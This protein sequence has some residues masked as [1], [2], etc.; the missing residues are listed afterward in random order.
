VSALLLAAGLA[1][2]ISS[3]LAVRTTR[4][5]RR[6]AR[7]HAAELSRLGA[8]HADV[9]AELT[10][11][12]ADEAAELDRARDDRHAADRAATINKLASSIGH[13]INNPLTSVLSNLDLI[14]SG[15]EGGELDVAELSTMT[16]EALDG[17]HRVRQIVKYLRMFAGSRAAQPG[18]CHELGRFAR[19]AIG[20]VKAEVRQRAQLVIEEADGAPPVLGDEGGLAQIVMCMVEHAVQALPTGRSR[21]HQLRV[22]VRLRGEAVELVVEA[23]RTAAAGPALALPA[24]FAG[25]LGPSLEVARRLAADLGSA[26]ELGEDDG[27]VRLALAL[28]PAEPAPAPRGGLTLRAA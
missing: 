4:A 6:A 14:R 8:V 1:A 16:D 17:A 15:L 5:A 24:R 27:V 28:P 3:G 23:R 9:V 20:L 13:E 18:R 11:A 10:R 22:V 7:A 2:L 26:L 21:D 25:C 19:F 12:H